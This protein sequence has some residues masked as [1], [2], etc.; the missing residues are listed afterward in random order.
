MWRDA[1]INQADSE[2]LGSNDTVSYFAE[3]TNSY[4][5]HGVSEWLQMLIKKWNV[6]V[7]ERYK[8]S[9]T[10]EH[11]HLIP[12]ISICAMQGL[13]VITFIKFFQ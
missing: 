13:A 12:E 6:A 4:E 2:K 5:V 3:I 8:Y 10:Y 11:D 7:T 1:I 9:N